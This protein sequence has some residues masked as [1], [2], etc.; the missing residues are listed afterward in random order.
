MLTVEQWS[1]EIMKMDSTFGLSAMR[2]GANLLVRI[3]TKK[4]RRKI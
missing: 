4:I 1:V 3:E 2:G